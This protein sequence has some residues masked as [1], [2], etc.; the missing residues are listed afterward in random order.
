[1][2]YVSIAI[3]GKEK[4][5]RDV[6]QAIADPTRRAILLLIAAHAMTPNAIAEHFNSTR[7][8]VSKHLKILTECELLKQKFTGREIYY[9][10]NANKMKDIDKWLAQFRKIWETR[11]S[12]LDTVLAKLKQ[13]KQ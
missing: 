5:R 3:S 2:W 13:D 7:Q 1:M 8:A 4:M 11:F 9:E 12:Q 6:F 10:V